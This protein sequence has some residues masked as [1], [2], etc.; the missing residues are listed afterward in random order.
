MIAF[1]ANDGSILWQ[2]RTT[3]PVKM[4]PIVAGGKVYFGDIAGMLYA[5]DAKTGAVRTAIPSDKP[6]ATS[7][8]VIIGSTLFIANSDT[9][10]AIPLDKL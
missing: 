6:Y 10:K 2:T 5:L 3:G 9:I 7:P 4:S 1:R 8:P